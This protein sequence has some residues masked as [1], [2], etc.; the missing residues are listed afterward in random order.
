MGLYV[1]YKG[2]LIGLGKNIVDSIKVGCW[3]YS[4]LKCQQEQVDVFFVSVGMLLQG[5]DVVLCLICQ[6]VQGDEV[7][8]NF[9]F[10]DVQILVGIEND[11]YVEVGYCVNF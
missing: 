9:L 10:N 2:L 5:V 6:G 1:L 7:Y 11:L 4:D 8:V 3:K